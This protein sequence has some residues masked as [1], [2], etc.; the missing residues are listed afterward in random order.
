MPQFQMNLDVNDW[1][2][3]QFGE[4]QLGDRRRTKRLVQI[5]AQAA[6]RPHGS[7][8]D[9]AEN[10]PDLKATYRL[11]DCDKVSFRAIIEP[12]LKHTTERLCGVT[13]MVSDTTELEFGC[14]RDVPG[15]GPTGDGVGRGF[16]LHSTVAVDRARG[17]IMDLA[18]QKLFCRQPAPKKETKTQRLNRERESQIWG[19]SVSRLQTAPQGA[20]FRYVFD[21]AGDNFETFCQLHQQQAQWVIRAAQKHRLVLD[22]EGQKRRL[23]ELVAEQPPV[24]TYHVKLQKQTGQ[25]PRTVKVELRYATLEMP[26]PHATSGWVRESGIQQISMSVVE[27]RA[28]ADPKDDDPIRWLLLTS[29]III[30][31]LEAKQVVSDYEKRWVVEEY[32]KALKTGCRV[33]SRQY[34]TGERLQRVIG[35]LSIVGVRLLQLRAHARLTPD[36]PALEVV[37]RD[38]VQLLP[39]ARHRGRAHSSSE[40][41]TVR[42]FYRCLAKLGGFVGRKRDGEPGWITIW[43]G[44]EKLQLILRGV[45]LERSRCG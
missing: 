43:R 15:L 4:C 22:C 32:H 28:V 35:L 39:Q 45:Q 3:E 11:F 23:D 6:Q 25:L 9:Q 10:W 2:H 18:E 31:V 30:S 38:W 26:R 17:E 5:A 13:L 24:D 44:F 29:D 19:E 36:R 40:Q 20:T 8:P 16:L 34:E 21:R 33:E 12:H 14:H 1:A 37:P 27:V 41:I 42:E 7:T